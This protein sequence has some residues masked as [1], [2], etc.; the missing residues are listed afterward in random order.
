MWQVQ[1]RNGI[2]NLILIILNVTLNTHIRIVS[3]KEECDLHPTSGLIFP[4]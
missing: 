2:S 1:L 4:G 3:A